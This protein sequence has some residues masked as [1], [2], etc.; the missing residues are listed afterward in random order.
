M[1]SSVSQAQVLR[2]I[3]GTHTDRAETGTK[4][5]PNLVNLIWGLIFRGTKYRGHQP[6]DSA[7]ETTNIY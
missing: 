3:L 7:I 5:E 1:G 6:G 4:Q 2:F